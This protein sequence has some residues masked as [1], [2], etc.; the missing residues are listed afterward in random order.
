MK[1]KRRPIEQQSNIVRMLK[2][3]I[4]SHSMCCL[5]NI[6]SALL[7][8]ASDEKVSKERMIRVGVEGAHKN[9]IFYFFS[10]NHFSLPVSL[11]IE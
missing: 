9:H 6:G 7:V 5:T 8:L 3:L 2:G 1:W 10:N 4:L 11:P